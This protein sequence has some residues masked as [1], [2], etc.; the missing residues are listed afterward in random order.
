MSMAK[1]KVEDKPKFQVQVNL[2]V[3]IHAADDMAALA[4]VLREI[5]G[6]MIR[7]CVGRKVK[8]FEVKGIEANGA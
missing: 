3:N 8:W 2:V 4:T 5:D 1:V 6:M 7:G